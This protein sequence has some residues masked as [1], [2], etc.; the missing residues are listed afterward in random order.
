MAVAMDAV[1]A[2]AERIAA[3][4]GLEVVEADFTGAGKARALR[5][6]VEKDIAG[7]EN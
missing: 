1:R 4:H 3:R 7:R 6:F 5:V 2:L